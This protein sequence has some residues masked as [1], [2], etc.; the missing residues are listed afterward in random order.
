MT[1]SI[2]FLKVINRGCL[3][4]LMAII[5]HNRA[6]NCID[7]YGRSIKIKQHFKLKKCCFYIHLVKME[8]IVKAKILSVFLLLLFILQ[9]A[10][11]FFPA[12][13]YLVSLH[14]LLCFCVKQDRLL[15]S[16]HPHNETSGL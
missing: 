10:V 7:E 16:F 11:D 15:Q 2:F 12:Q 3:F 14:L 1:V 13:A 9:P 6:I 8:A 5:M 4:V